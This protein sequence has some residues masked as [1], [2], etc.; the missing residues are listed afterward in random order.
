MRPFPARPWTGHD[1]RWRDPL[2]PCAR[3]VELPA[4]NERESIAARFGVLAR[5]LPKQEYSLDLKLLNAIIHTLGR[6]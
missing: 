2:Q 5:F 6:R 4:L 3:V 1:C